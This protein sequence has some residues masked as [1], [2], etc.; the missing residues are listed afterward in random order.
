M[1]VLTSKSNRPCIYEFTEVR[2]MSLNK[3]YFGDY[4]SIEYKVRTK[5]I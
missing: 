2:E 5:E 3:V 4:T 1:S